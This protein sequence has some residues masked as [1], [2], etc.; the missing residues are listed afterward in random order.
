[1]AH[2]DTGVL[3]PVLIEQAGDALAID[4]QVV[5]TYGNDG[6]RAEGATVTASAI[7]A[8]GITSITLE[9]ASAPGAYVGTLEV[10]EPGEVTVLVES[11]DPSATLE[12]PV[13]IVEP[14]VEATTTTTSTTTEVR[15]E[16]RAVEAE[17][18]DANDNSAVPTI[19]LLIVVAIGAGIAYRLS[20]RSRD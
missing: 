8:R 12:V 13:V 14:Q 20:R 16:P 6:E 1:M 7:S 3:E 19:L 4:V 11:T 17:E 9:P 10:P 2:G 5:L 18:D 15:S